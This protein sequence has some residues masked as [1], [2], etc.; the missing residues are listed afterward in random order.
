M[1][2]TFFFEWEVEL[3][4]WLQSFL[5]SGIAVKIASLITMLGEEMVCIG[6]LGFFYWGINKQLGKDI[7]INIAA[8]V[9]WNPMIKNVFNRRRPYFD[10]EGIKCLKPVDG[11]ADIYDIPAQGFSFPSGHSSNSATVFGTLARFTQKTWVRV[12][13]ILIPVL[14]GISRFV[15]GVHYPTDVFVGWILG[16][17]IVFFIPWLKKKINNNILFYG[18]LLVTAL[19]GF[20]Y[21]KSYDFYSGYG[22]LLGAAIGFTFE[23]KFVNF[24]EAGNI[25]RAILRTV[26]GGG[27]FLGLNTLFKLP[28]SKEFLE[29]GTHAS[30]IV[31]A[32]RYTVVVF[33][34]VAIYPMVFKYTSK[35]G[36][37]E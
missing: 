27:L 6:V 13:L 18:I 37:K 2:N 21:C 8:N 35:I 11:D 25:F 7:G 9:V 5:G 12:V 32:G 23:E 30:Q 34:I 1:G 4:Q 36:K 20:F 19:P 31:K 24:E 28:F 22:I 33:L 29:N 3:M 15:L 16:A 26:V 14:V 10:N 17:A